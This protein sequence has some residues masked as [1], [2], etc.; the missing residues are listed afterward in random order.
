MFT[1]RLAQANLITKTDSDY[2]LKGINKKL[3]QTK[4]KIYWLRTNWKNYKRLIQFILEGKAI[5]KNM[6]HKII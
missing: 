5:L 3:T 6:G 4:Q 2:K 1:A